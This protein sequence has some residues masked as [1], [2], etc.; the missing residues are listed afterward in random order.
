L[1]LATVVDARA[2]SAAPIAGDDS[3]DVRYLLEERYARRPRSARSLTAYYRV[4]PFVPRGA[5]L[6]ARRA[7]ARR[8]RRRHEE[9]IGRASCRERV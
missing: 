3:P 4:K 5:Q 7:Y 9:Q 6:V 2:P 1:S 8:I